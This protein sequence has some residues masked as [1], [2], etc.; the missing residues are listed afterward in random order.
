MLSDLSAESEKYMRKIL[1]DKKRIKLF[2]LVIIILISFFFRFYKLRDFLIFGM[3]QENEI[4]IVDN[5]VSG[6]HFPLI[7][8]SSSD[9]GIYRGPAFL[10][11]SAIPY[12]LFDGNPVG[13]AI[14][15]SLLGLI[16]SLLIYRLGSKMFSPS[17]G[18]L[19]A[20]LYCGSFLVAYYDRQFW[21]PTFIPL[22]SL[23]I[24]CLC[25]NVMRK[26]SYFL[27]IV[28]ILLFGI[29]THAHLTILIFTPLII[30]T[31]WSIRKKLSFKKWFILLFF[32]VVTQLP[33][34]LFDIRHDFLNTKAM[35]STLTGTNLTRI[36]SS[37][38]ERSNLFLS[39]LGRYI[40]VPPIADFMVESGQCKELLPFIKSQT[41]LGMVL[42]LFILGCLVFWKFKKPTDANMS[43]GLYIPVVLTFLTLLFIVFYNHQIFQYYFSYF[44]PW[45]SLLLGWCIV[46]LWRQKYAK[47]ILFAAVVLFVLLNMLTMVTARYSFSYKEKIDALQFVSKKLQ[48]HPFSLEALGECPR[49]GGQRYLAQYTVGTPIHSY[50]DS[51]FAWLYPDTIKSVPTAPVVLLS[52]IDSRMKEDL[53]ARWE[54]MKIRYLNDYHDITNSRFGKINVFI[55]SPKLNNA[56]L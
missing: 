17:I 25:F 15:A 2:L 4:L 34:I 37:I 36:S 9:T 29:A 28:L 1:T 55:L 38:S 11:L 52:M 5:I 12:I 51:Y 35:I 48:N 27:S 19:G 41:V 20:L 46:F 7:G 32:L 31:L 18:F 21:N 3:D 23:L 50:M 22:L 43:K 6:R 26:K 14:T 30:Y 47:Y 45:L 49:Y 16:V 42:V 33:L 10:Y 54:E 44:F 40:W 56:D 53:V 24:G 13:G 8:L 39:T